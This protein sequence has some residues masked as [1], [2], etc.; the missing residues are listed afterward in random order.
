MQGFTERVQFL[1]SCVR[2]QLNKN[3]IFFDATVDSETWGFEVSSI[4]A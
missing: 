1:F 2:I 4:K 3:T